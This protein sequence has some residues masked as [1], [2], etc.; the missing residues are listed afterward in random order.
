MRKRGRK[1]E[2]EPCLPDLGEGG[3]LESVPAEGDYVYWSI[4]R[5]DGAK[6][7]KTCISG[8]D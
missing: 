4:Q 5:G 1:G 2:G 3:S 7:G 6:K 8:R